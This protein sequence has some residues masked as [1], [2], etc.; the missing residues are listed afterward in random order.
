VGGLGKGLRCRKS[1]KPEKCL[2]IAQTP[3][4]PLHALLAGFTQ[5]SLLENQNRHH[6]TDRIIARTLCLRKNQKCNL[7]K[8]LLKKTLPN[9]PEHRFGKLWRT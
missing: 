1:S 8:R 2:K 9:Q 3:T 6:K 7:R 5:D 4:R